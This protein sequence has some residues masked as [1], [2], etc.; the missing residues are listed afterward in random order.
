MDDLS[1]RPRKDSRQA[2]QRSTTIF[3]GGVSHNVRYEPP[4][5]LYID[6]ADGAH[7]WDIDGNRYVDFWNNHNAS[8][9][10]HCHPAVVERIRKQARNGLHYGA[11]NELMLELGERVQQIIPSAERLRF[12]ASGTEAAMYCVRLARAATGRDHVLKVEGAWHGGSTDLTS[13]VN[14]PFDAPTT[15][16]LPPGTNDFVHSFPLNDREA[17][18][19]LLQRFKDDVAAVILDPRNSGFFSDESFV[20]FLNEQRET[21]DYQ[22]IFDEV[23]T[24]FRLAEGSYQ[25]QIGVTPDLTALGKVLGGGL[26][27]GALAGRTELFEATR[28]DI[29]VPPE[30]RVIGGGGTFAANPMTLIAGIETLD[31]IE[32]EPVYD[33]TESLG[34]LL[35]EGL[36]QVFSEVGVHG[37]VLGMSSLIQPVFGIENPRSPTELKTEADGDA[38]RAY[39]NRLIDEGYYF[40]PGHIGNISY[41]VTE[42]DVNGVIDVSR[43]ILLDMY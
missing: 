34:E 16:G 25:A 17:F 41:R 12:C 30:R 7:I 28:P 33:H 1:R 43:S 5:P 26:P 21:H 15:N 32:K 29:D 40:L 11:P 20:Q 10:G 13:G 37:T 8:I 22:L 38:L 39:H 18:A 3:P 2:H 19:S 31:V 23:I 14:P 35:R 27:I 42:E 9:L 4:H 24:G 36:T 6:H